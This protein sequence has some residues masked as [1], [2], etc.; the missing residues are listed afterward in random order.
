MTKDFWRNSLYTYTVIYTYYIIIGFQASYE[1]SLLQ[2]V[3]ENATWN[4]NLILEYV[5]KILYFDVNNLETDWLSVTHKY[6]SCLQEFYSNFG[7]WSRTFS[8][9][10]IALGFILNLFIYILTSSLIW[11]SYIWWTLTSS[12]VTLKVYF[13][14]LSESDNWRRGK[15][16]SRAS[17]NSFIFE[18]KFFYIVLHKVLYSFNKVFN[19]SSIL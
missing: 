14:V 1:Q 8:S 2:G 13:L 16:L 7:Q 3:F 4:D 6:Y 10:Y 5:M 9:T 15:Q 18:L 11:V 17:T 19:R 12:D